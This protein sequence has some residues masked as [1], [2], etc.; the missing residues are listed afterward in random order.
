MNYRAWRHRYWLVTRMSLK[1]VDF[2]RICLDTLVI[3]KP[4]ESDYTEDI[5]KMQG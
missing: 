3:Y 4:L 1:Q 5:L 2:E